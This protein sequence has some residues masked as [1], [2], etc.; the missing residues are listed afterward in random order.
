ML[1]GPGWRPMRMKTP[2]SPRIGTNASLAKPQPR[3]DRSI[4][5]PTRSAP[6]AQEADKKVN[7]PLPQGLFDLRKAE[8]TGVNG[9]NNR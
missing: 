6:D 4:P 2:E 7:R 3:L 9:V 1:T 8:I 5:A